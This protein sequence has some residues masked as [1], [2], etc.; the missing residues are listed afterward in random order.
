MPRNRILFLSHFWVSMGLFAPAVLL[1]A[2]QMLERSPLPAPFANPSAYY[3][4]VTAHGTTMAYVITTF[5]AMGMGYAIC[6]D[7]ARPPNDRGVTPGP[8]SASSICAVRD[9]FERP[10]AQALRG[11]AVGAL[12]L[13]PAAA[14]A[15]PSYYVGVLAVVVGSWVWCALMARQA[16]PSYKRRASRPDRPVP[17]WPCSRSWRRPSSGS[18][19][20][21]A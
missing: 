14:R 3:A 5:F 19:L 13:L 20:P 15:S 7:H 21:S 8:G 18:G 10:R 1:G 11:P 16:W 12:H 9:R 2:W 6:R 17:H 4:S